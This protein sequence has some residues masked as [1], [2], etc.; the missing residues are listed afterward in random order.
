[1][2]DHLK[3]DKAQVESLGTDAGDVAVEVLDLNDEAQVAW[4]EHAMR[5]VKGVRTDLDAATD[6]LRRVE[7]EI[8]RAKS[9]A[10]LAQLRQA[11]A[12][13]LQAIAEGELDL[14]R[15]AP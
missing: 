13:A 4:R 12:E 3:Y 10:H 9:P 1:M 7:K 11:E 6:R 14:E 15:L 8:R 2:S 5:V